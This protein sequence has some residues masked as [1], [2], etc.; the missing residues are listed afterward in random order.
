MGP[1]VRVI[2]SLGRGGSQDN[3]L[4]P[5]QDNGLI[6]RHGRVVRKSEEEQDGEAERQK[7]T[8]NEEKVTRGIAA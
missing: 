5:G 7:K 2:S 6:R 1:K 4:T 3:N 8:Q